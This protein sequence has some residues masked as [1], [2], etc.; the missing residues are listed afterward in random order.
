M[1]LN[2]NCT[3]HKRWCKTKLR[4]SRWGFLLRKLAIVLR[5][6]KFLI[7]EILF[8]FVT[9]SHFGWMSHTHPTLVRCLWAWAV[10][11][12]QVFIRN[13]GKGFFGF[14]F[15]IVQMK[16]YARYLK[17]TP[18]VLQWG[19]WWVEQWSNMEMSSSISYFLLWFGWRWRNCPAKYQP[20]RHFYC[21]SSAFWMIIAY[22]LSD[23]RG[24]TSCK[25]T[26][27]ACYWLHRKI[28]SF[29]ILC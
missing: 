23:I 19:G 27:F 8:S 1:W 11:L 26:T 15:M 6:T 13:W 20:R 10:H 21:T 16:Y 9:G 18:R 17:T 24:C 5:M 7:I 14:I 3:H 2:K 22:L 12:Q 29:L 28:L 25:L 4:R